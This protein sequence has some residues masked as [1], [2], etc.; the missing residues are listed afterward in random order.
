MRINLLNFSAACLT[1]L[2]LAGLLLPGGFS[3]QG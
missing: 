2:A 1:I 3:D